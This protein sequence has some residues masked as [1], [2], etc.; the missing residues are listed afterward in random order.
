MKQMKLKLTKNITKYN[1]NRLSSILVNRNIK[2]E[3]IDE[4]FKSKKKKFL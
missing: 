2:E 3:D 1:L 4:F